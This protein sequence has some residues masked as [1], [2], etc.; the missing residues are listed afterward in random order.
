MIR[1]KPFFN[2][3]RDFR[4][5]IVANHRIRFPE[6][7]VLDE[8]GEMVGIMPIRDA[9]N[10]AQ[11]A[12]KD[13]VLVT[14]Q[15]KPPVVKIIE[16]AK[17]K[18]Q[19]Q[20]KEAESRKKSKSQDT[21]EIHLTPFMGEGDLEYRLKKIIGYLEKGDKVRLSLEFKGRSIT[22]KEFGFDIVNRVIKETAE[23][24]KVEIEPKLMGKKLMAQLMPV[25]K[26]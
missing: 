5:D 6:V 3:Q 11:E 7:R 20:Q 26:S 9:M 12:E 19:L 23:L 21:K 25:K 10:H 8:H 1:K 24:A 4:V 18:Y 13:L 16:L 17:Y 15:A 22:K 2:K 14:G